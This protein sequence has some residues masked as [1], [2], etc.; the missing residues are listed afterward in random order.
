MLALSG[1]GDERFFEIAFPKIIEN[2]LKGRWQ[3]QDDFYLAFNTTYIYKKMSIS[4]S[5]IPTGLAQAAPAPAN[6]TGG[7]T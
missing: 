3:Q 2:Y 5:T 4:Q 7:P 6:S 1:Y